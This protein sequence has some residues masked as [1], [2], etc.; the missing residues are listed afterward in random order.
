M[1]TGGLLILIGALILS[2]AAYAAPAITPVYDNDSFR[3]GLTLPFVVEA[4]KNRPEAVISGL[5]LQAANE[6]SVNASAECAIAKDKFLRTHF[7][8]ICRS[9]GK[10]NLRIDVLEGTDV[11]T[12][13]YGPVTI[14][15]LKPGYIEPT[16]LDPKAD[17]DVAK[18]RQIMISKTEL[19]SPFRSCVSC[20]ST[21]DTH[22]LRTKATKSTLM[23]LNSKS[24][25][26]A[27]PNLTSTEA[28]QVL[29]YLRTI[30][31]GKVWP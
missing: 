18:G 7:L 31:D 12:I 9:P 15:P 17:P 14:N 26:S 29:K 13:N 16:P 25:M 19:V 8:V 5:S 11:K 21:P 6:A 2:R 27:V 1:K 22:G 24:L 20:H 10:F 30:Q 3:T 4:I 23:N 28:D